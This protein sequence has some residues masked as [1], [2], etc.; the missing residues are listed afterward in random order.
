MKKRFLL[1][2]GLIA[3]TACLGCGKVNLPNTLEES[4][5]S[6]IIDDIDKDDHLSFLDQDPSEDT[7]AESTTSTEESLQNPSALGNETDTS[8]APSSTPDDATLPTPEEQIDLIVEKLPELLTGNPF[9]YLTDL[10]ENGRLELIL[11]EQNFSLYEVNE[12][13]DNLVHTVFIDG[14]SDN[15]PDVYS[16]VNKYIFTDREGIHHY[17]WGGSTY[18]SSDVVRTYD[19]EYIYINGSMMCENLRS[20]TYDSSNGENTEL[21][22]SY[23]MDEMPYEEYANIFKDMYESGDYIMQVATIDCRQFSNDL[24]ENKKTTKHILMDLWNTFQIKDADLPY[25]YNDLD[26]SYILTGGSVEGCD[27]EI[28]PSEDAKHLIFHDGLI[29]FVDDGFPE[30]NRYTQ[31]M[32]GNLCI[33]SPLEFMPWELYLLENQVFRYGA[34]CINEEGTVYFT[35]Q[36]MYNDTDYDSVLWY[37]EKE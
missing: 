34:I 6:P 5:S 15:F 31:D 23:G 11:L 8:Q 7:S 12:S 18:I 9:L 27:F 3:V 33:G 4:P 1:L 29:D 10:D 16:L 28:D 2:A 25:F 32:V 13:G 21:I 22:Y 37:F 17:I 14:N 26:G 19:N 30:N 24:L 35:A 20:A 36:F